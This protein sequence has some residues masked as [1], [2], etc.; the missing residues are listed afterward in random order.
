MPPRRRGGTGTN[1]EAVRRHNLGDA[2][3]ARA[4]LGWGLPRPADRADGAEPL[5]H[6]GPGPRARGARRGHPVDARG[7]CASGSARASVHR[8]EPVERDG[9]RARRRAGGRH[10]GRGPGGARWRARW[11]GCPRSPRS[12]GTPT[13]LVDTLVEMM[14]SILKTAADGRQPRRHRDRGPRRR[15]RPG[16]GWCRFAPNLGWKDV[17]VSHMVAGKIG[18]DVPGAHRQRRR[19]RCPVPSTPAAPAA[20]S[21]T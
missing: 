21:P 6:R 2:A 19:A 5:H 16:W 13:H 15:H 4:P 1:Q 7:G 3:G 12:T 10:H 8:R 18:H 9:V 11:T 14:R 17:P 20:T